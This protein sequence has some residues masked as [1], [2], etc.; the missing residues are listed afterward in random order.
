MSDDGLVGELLHVV[1]A[2][3]F[4]HTVD[5][6]GS[7]RPEMLAALDTDSGEHIAAIVVAAFLGAMPSAVDVDGGVDLTFTDLPL[8]V[9]TDVGCNDVVQ[10]ACFE[11]KSMRGDFRRFFNQRN[12]K[13]G[14]SHATTIKKI[15]HIVEEARRE[16][17][18]A[19][20]AL[21][22]KTDETQSRNIVVVV[23]SFEHL[24]IEAIE[25][26]FISNFLDDPRE[27]LADVASIWFVI[28]PSHVVRWERSRQRWVNLGSVGALDGHPEGSDSF[29]DVLMSS[30]QQFCESFR[31]GRQSAWAVFREGAPLAWRQPGDLESARRTER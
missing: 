15:A 10:S 14:D 12:T 7:I 4:P 18:L 22:A 27:D 19:A 1:S 17:R 8:N 24:A 21:R 25:N 23:H 13:I 26:L 28:Y 30:E 3:T 11:I 31:D 20:D 16:V 5:E 29:S 6:L 2:I 9:A